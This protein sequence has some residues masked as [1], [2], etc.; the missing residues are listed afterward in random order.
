MALFVMVGLSTLVMSVGLYTVG[1][2][3]LWGA[4]G[5]FMIA[6]FVAA[7]ASVLRDVQAEAS[8]VRIQPQTQFARRA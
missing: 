8:V 4:V 3:G 7:T 6:T 1:M 2:I 5:L